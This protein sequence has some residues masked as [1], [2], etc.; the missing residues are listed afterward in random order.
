[1]KKISLLLAL[2]LVATIATTVAFENLSLQPEVGRSP[3]D[4]RHT[5]AYSEV[6]TDYEYEYNAFKGEFQLVPNF[7]TEY[8][9]EAWYVQYEITY[10]DGS[11]DTEWVEVGETEYDRIKAELGG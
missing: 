8:Y 9:P 6:E 10:A 3:I 2:V 5:D 11:T 7:H 1:M 4:V